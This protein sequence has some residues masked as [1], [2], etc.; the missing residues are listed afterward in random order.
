MVLLVTLGARRELGQQT[1]VG[2]AG[3]TAITAIAASPREADVL[4]VAHPAGIQV[5]RDGGT[6]WQSADFAHTARSVVAIEAGLLAITDDGQ[7]LAAASSAS[8]WVSAPSLSN[9]EMLAAGRHSPRLIGVNAGGTIQ[10]AFD[11]GVTWRVLD[12][13]A[14]STV[15]G[16]AVVVTPEPLLLLGTSTEGVLASTKRSTWR[17][18][19]GFVKGALPTVNIRSLYYEPVGTTPGAAFC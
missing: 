17:S 15:T 16:I 8:N 13:P 11:A 7:F 2:N 9:V 18:A 3:V 14:P 10:E 19:N 4:V 6:K 12:L 1:I 5:S